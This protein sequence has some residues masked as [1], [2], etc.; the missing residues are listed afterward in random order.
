FGEEVAGEDLDA[1]DRLDRDEVE[2]DHPPLARRR[3]DPVGGDLRPAA[4]RRAEIDDA[5]AREQDVVLV[6]DLG[7][8]EGRP[9]A[10][11]A[12][13][14]FRHIGI[15][16]LPLEPAFRGARAAAR[17]LHPHLQP[18]V[19]AAARRHGTGSSGPAATGA[20]PPPAPSWRR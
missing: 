4:R 6:V 10:I 1:L 15:V 3:L 9:R 11:A 2:G 17:G 20:A 12:G 7:E 16:E 8:L 14:G 18:A 5:R 19:A 13:P